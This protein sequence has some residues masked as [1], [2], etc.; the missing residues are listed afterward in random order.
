MNV[1]KAWYSYLTYIF[2][3]VITAVS[4]TEYVLLLWS[5]SYVTSGTNAF[6]RWIISSQFNYRLV[7][8][9]FIFSVYALLIVVFCLVTIAARKFRKKHFLNQHTV[10]AW[11]CVVILLITAGGLAYKIYMTAGNIPDT[12][13][14]MSYLKWAQ[15]SA[16]SSIPDVQHGASMLYLYILYV[17]MSFLGNKIMTA[18]MLQIALQ[19]LTLIVLYFAV[20]IWTGRVPAVITCA[21]FAFSSIINEKLF[22]ANPECLLFL[23]YS[24]MLLLCGIYCRSIVRL[25]NGREAFLAIILGA[26]VGSVCYMDLTGFTLFVML[27]VLFIGTGNEK[28]YHIIDFLLILIAAFA[29]VVGLIAFK[30]F[31]SGNG[32]MEEFSV[33]TGIMKDSFKLQLFMYSSDNKDISMLECFLL[34]FAAAAFIPAFWLHDTDHESCFMILMAVAWTP[35]TGISILSENIFS[36]FIWSVMAGIGIQGMTVHPRREREKVKLHRRSKTRKVV[37]SGNGQDETE[38]QSD[39]M[40][41][42]IPAAARS[43]GEGN[44]PENRIM[45]RQSESK[46]VKPEVAGQRTDPVQPVNRALPDNKVQPVSA[47]V[48]EKKVPPVTAA[49]LTKKVPPASA[50]VPEKKVPPVAA[51]APVKKEHASAAKAAESK[52]QPVHA[53]ASEIKPAAEMS[54]KDYIDQLWAEINNSVAPQPAAPVTGQAAKPSVQPAAPVAQQ[55]A[56]LQPQRR[57]QQ[58]YRQNS[59]RKRRYSL[60]QSRPQR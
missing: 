31:L 46:S 20:R 16:G 45:L 40:V 11:E 25:P 1:K 36:I 10:S 14:D 43:T 38:Q 57:S 44:M 3:T 37:I 6:T 35:M 56:S 7:M 59:R 50:Y 29:A 55:A 13:S 24:V 48:P 17:F 9:L 19:I 28:L 27:L 53:A 26:A 18:V 23:I 22:E 58:S 54:T 49:A 15:V 41:V 12:L 5:G 2:F 8:G 51:A 32:F 34:T 52:V 39:G 30:S 21:V 4:L 47:Y 42:Q 33:W 60:Q